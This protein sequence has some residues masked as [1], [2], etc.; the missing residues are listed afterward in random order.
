MVLKLTK[1]GVA[2]FIATQGGKPVVKLSAKTA[3]PLDQWSKLRVEIDG[4]TARLFVNGKP[5]A[6]V[7][8]SFRA[9]DVALADAP[10]QNF[11]GNSRQKN[12]PLM[13]T[14]DELVI[15]SQVNDDFASLP[16]PV[17]DAPI[18]PS[19]GV[20]EA[21]AAYAKYVTETN[22]K[23]KKATPKAKPADDKAD[24]QY[25]R[26]H[27]GSKYATQFAYYDRMKK[28][29]A[30][31]T[32]ELNARDDS[33]SKAEA[34]LAAKQAEKLAAKKELLKKAALLP[35]VTE[36]KAKLD[37]LNKQCR[38]LS[39][40]FNKA[41]QAYLNADPKLAALRKKL[42]ELQ[43]TDRRGQK[44]ETRDVRHRMHTHERTLRDPIESLPET[45]AYRPAEKKRNH[46][47]HQVRRLQGEYV[48]RNMAR[49]DQEIGTLKNAVNEARTR[50]QA[51]YLQ[52]YRALSYAYGAAFRG[53]YNFPLIR[54]MAG[55]AETAATG[56]L[57]PRGNASD[58]QNRLEQWN[59]PNAWRT[60]IDWDWRYGP[61]AQGNDLE[62]RP[63]MKRWIERV[64]G[65][66]VTKRPVGTNPKQ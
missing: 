47:Q 39:Q 1:K 20:V 48:T 53:H 21:V 54:F 15:Y 59:E 46:A 41:R 56:E 50:A 6:S 8:T 3:L 66:I 65:P 34:N 4:K 58:V 35:E 18:R 63:M 22:A 2:K 45:A 5:E 55:D 38:P 7:K 51:P 60:E 30:E 11:L 9:C 23:L 61:E 13:G 14:L 26:Q 31:R 37:Q 25:A 17:I 44:K 62:N 33:M 42:K 10:Q 28:R 64:R 57:Q 43:K 32:K 12:R 40:A 29:I 24:G 27:A 52:E 49:I 16:R 19:Q 36:A